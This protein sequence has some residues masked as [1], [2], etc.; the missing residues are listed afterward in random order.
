MLR[1]HADRLHSLILALDHLVSGAVC[2]AVLS[3]PG[4]MLPT[5]SGLP[6]RALAVALVAT[7]LWPFLFEQIGLYGSQRRARLL[8]VVGRLC[9]AGAI[10][11]AVVA[12]LAYAISAPLAP[13]FPVVCSAAQ[14]LVLGS[15]RVAILFG[16]RFA[17]RH[18]RNFRNVLVVGSG[19]RARGAAA[20]IEQNPE[21]GLR[22]LCFAD[23]AGEAVDPALAGRPII[24]LSEVPMLFREEVV[25]EVV[26]ACPRAMLP[27][28]EPVA[29][30]CASVGVPMT[31]FSDLFGDYL[32][33][34]RSSRFGGVPAL[35]FAM[36]H[37]SPVKLACKRCIDVAGAAVLLV[38][39]APLLAIAALAIRLTTPGPVLFRQVRC[40]L[41]GRRFDMIKLRTMYVDAEQR[42]QEL[43]ALNEASGPVFKMRN[44]P[45]VTPVGR[46]LRRWSI[47]E[48][49]QLWNVLVGHM[50]LVGPRPPIPAEVALYDIAD[51]RRLSMRPGLTCLWQVRGR[52]RIGFE[53]W[54][55]LDLEYIDRW[56]LL[57]DLRILLATVPAVVR[58]TGAS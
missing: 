26:V 33:P 16:L 23:E 55:R 44:D 43:L 24:K 57:R 20:L 28:I 14:L 53:E 29:A 38:A 48:L 22:I 34:P 9:L 21:W 10:A 41:Y 17:R 52:S 31:L 39:T 35:S 36:V 40:G 12:A 7:F 32:P 30:A 19:P 3:L 8:D 45:R 2:L 27:A 18:G 25:D 37:H 51:R 4:M 46:W 13:S 1:S 42:K 49:P 58:G 56:S 5:G 15:L 47:D 54:V 50:S 6:F 11:T